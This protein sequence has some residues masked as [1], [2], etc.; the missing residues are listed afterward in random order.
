MAF[1]HKS[2]DD[3][4]AVTESAWVPRLDVLLHGNL[5]LEGSSLLFFDVGANY[6]FGTTDVYVRES[7]R[8]HIPSFVG[9][10]RM[11]VGARF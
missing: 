1:T 11:G 5:D 10:A 7:L 9:I 6:R 8:A 3:P 2:D 4:F